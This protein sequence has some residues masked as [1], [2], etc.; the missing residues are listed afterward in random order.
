MESQIEPDA[1]EVYSSGEFF[2][3]A[4]GRVHRLFRNASRTEVAKLL[5]F[6]VGYTGAATPHVKATLKN[7]MGQEVRL[8]RLSLM[9]GASME[10]RANENPETLYV[11]EGRIEIEY[12]DGAKEY[13]AG[14]LFSTA[15]ATKIKIKNSSEPAA[16][17][18]FQVSE[19]SAQ[20]KE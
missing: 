14:S 9:R 8:S 5:T 7:M 15:T 4:P 12:A 6:Q 18:L 16:L 1:P 13:A 2:L 17:L 19:R 10:L 20:S 3:E 11:L